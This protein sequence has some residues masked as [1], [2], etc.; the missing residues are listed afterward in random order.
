MKQL[1]SS[2]TLVIPEGVSVEVKARRVRVKGPRGECGNAL[3]GAPCSAAMLHAGARPGA[4]GRWRRPPQR[5]HPDV[6]AVGSL[7]APTWGGQP[8]R[9][10]PGSRLRSSAGRSKGATIAAKGGQKFTDGCGDAAES[11][12]RAEQQQRRRAAE[13][14]SPSSKQLR[15]TGSLPCLQRRNSKKGQRAQRGHMLPTASAAILRG[16]APL[17]S[18]RPPTG[19]HRPIAHLQAPCSATSSTLRWTCS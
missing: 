7:Y 2:R 11:A 18:S 1:I 16:R 6:A 3:E 13:A 14:E 5:G 12:A 19:C 17:P 8:P 15:T 9:R 10:P 4:L